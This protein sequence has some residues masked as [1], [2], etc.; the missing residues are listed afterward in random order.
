MILVQINEAHSTKWPIGLKDTPP[1]QLNFNDRV[2]RANNFVTNDN[3]PFTVLID[4]WDNSFDNMFRA[5]PDKYYCVD[6]N[7]KVIETSEYGMKH[8][9]LI[10]KDCIDLIIELIKILN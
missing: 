9:A 2:E 8:D 4:G 6:M 5:W 7:Y 10:N 3:C 1:P